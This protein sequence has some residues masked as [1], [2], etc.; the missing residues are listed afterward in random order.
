MENF[1]IIHCSCKF[2]TNQEKEQKKIQN[3]LKDKLKIKN[4][5]II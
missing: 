1:L 5:F 2:R 3:N 4:I